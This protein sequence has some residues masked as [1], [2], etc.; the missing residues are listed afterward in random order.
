MT[1]NAKSEGRI[2]KSDYIYIAKDDAQDLEA[3]QGLL[4][5]TVK[6]EPANL[7]A[8]TMMRQIAERTEEYTV[9]LESYE[10]ALKTRPRGEV[11]RKILADM[12]NVKWRVFG[13]MVGAEDAFKRVRKYYRMIEILAGLLM[14]IIGVLLV[15]D[16]FSV[17]ARALQKYLPTY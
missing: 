4:S 7:E 14:I 9:L 12:G 11:E 2:Y 5:Q 15:T 6:L 17:I 13:D 8:L 1:S 10:A 3:A 16:R